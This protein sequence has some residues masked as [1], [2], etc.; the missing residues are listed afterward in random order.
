M[1]HQPVTHLSALRPGSSELPLKETKCLKW[2]YADLRHASLL[3]ALGLRA[4]DVQR[5][6]TRATLIFN[7]AEYLVLLWASAILQLTFVLLDPRLLDAGREEQLQDYMRRLK[8]AIV[9]VPDGMGANTLNTALEA[10]DVE[11]VMKMVLDGAHVQRWRGL[12]DVATFHGGDVEN[13]DSLIAQDTALEQ[14][15]NR[16]AHRR[17]S[18][19]D[20]PEPSKTS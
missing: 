11:A 5:G 20:V 17:A 9:V 16:V 3:V 14:D 4:N 1:I 2:T 15:S 8:P 19:R 13:E 6:S 18:P 7:G 10:A 12:A